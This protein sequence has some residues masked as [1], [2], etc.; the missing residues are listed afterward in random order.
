MCFVSCYLL[1]ASVVAF[2]C[3][4]WNLRYSLEI[5]RLA[6]KNNKDI[7]TIFGGP[8]IPRMEPNVGAFFSRHKFIDVLVFGEG[9]VAFRE[10]LKAIIL[11]TD[12]GSIEGIVE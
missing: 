1:P 4:V 6:K 11:G 2:S 10:I 5:A 3:Y 9:E 12:F 7:R 8:S